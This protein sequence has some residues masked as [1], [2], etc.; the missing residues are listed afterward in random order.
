MNITVNSNNLQVN[1]DDPGPFL[2]LTGDLMTGPIT[3]LRTNDTTITLG[4]F[5]GAVGQGTN[6]VAIGRT[7]GQFNQGD[8]SLAI[9][10]RNTGVVNQHTSTVL[11]NGSNTGLVT[12]APDQIKMQA[13]STLFEADATTITHQGNSIAGDFKSDG[14]VALT[15]P[16]TN[17][18]TNDSAINLGANASAGPGGIAIG[19]SAAGSGAQIDDSIAIGSGAGEFQ[20][21]VEC[22]AI[23]RL[24]GQIQGD[25]AIAIGKHAGL[26]QPS[27]S[28]V[29][30]A[31]SS[32]GIN[33]T[34]SNQF[35]VQAGTTNFSVEPTTVTHQGNSI[36]GDL[37]S[38]GSVAMSGDLQVPTINGL[39]PTGGKWASTESTIINYNPIPTF[40]SLFGTAGVGSLAVAANGWQIGT[41]GCIKIGGVVTSP[42]NGAY[43]IRIVGGNPGDGLTQI[44]TSG[45]VTIASATTSQF[46]EIELEFTVRDLGSGL[47]NNLGFN[48]NF[49]YLAGGNNMEGIT[50]AGEIS[51]D[52]T[53][54][55]IFGADI[56]LNSPGMSITTHVASLSTLY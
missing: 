44:W 24:A 54:E 23:G 42:N 9:G 50:I 28:I 55:N 22:V 47:P 7:S 31:R 36:D 39:S 16:I 37:K 29:L 27:E 18:K 49:K 1:L 14:S 21:G 25:N 45:A 2:K 52:T 53:I 20:Q 38:D 3:N 33:P 26:N 48:G 5:A 12:S 40:S 41:T 8:Y 43:V 13:G 15:G 35:V 17:L 30:S 32:A 6:C 56:E 10:T 46:W 11:I 51:F 4:E 34:S 19:V